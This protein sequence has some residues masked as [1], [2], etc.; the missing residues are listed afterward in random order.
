MNLLLD[1]GNT[2]TKIA[3]YNDNIIV[4]TQTFKEI[5]INDIKKIKNSF[6][7][8]NVILSSVIYYKDEIKNFTK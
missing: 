8:N 7:I 4:E 2:N 1:F 3:V 5:H 6:S